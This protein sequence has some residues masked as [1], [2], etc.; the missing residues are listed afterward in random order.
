MK[1]LV[2]EVQW[3]LRFSVGLKES[4]GEIIKAGGKV[5]VTKTIARDNVGM[6][7]TLNGSA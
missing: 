6:E 2:A 3:L 1:S 7:N 4:K 5:L